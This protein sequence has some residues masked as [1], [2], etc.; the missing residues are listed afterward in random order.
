LRQK[1]KER[2]REMEIELKDRTI[3]DI[4]TNRRRVESVRN[5]KEEAVS[6]R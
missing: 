2:K 3:I 5:D 1:K 4:D 6:A